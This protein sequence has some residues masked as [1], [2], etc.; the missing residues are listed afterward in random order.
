M[1]KHNM[2]YKLLAVG[3]AIVIWA[4]SSP[5]P[6]PPV[7]KD[8][9]LPLDVRRVEPGCVVTHAPKSVVVRL[10][11]ARSHVDAVAAEPDSISAFVSLQGKGPGRH[12]LPVILKLPEGYVGL[13]NTVANPRRVQV[14]VSE[15]AR[16]VLDVGVQFVGSPPV[17]YRFGIP[18]I[19]PDRAVVSG[20]AQLV[21]RVARVAAIIDISGPN[22]GSV[23]SEFGL[24][25]LDAAGKQIQGVDIAPAKVHVRL[26]LLE[27]P[28]SRAVFVSLNA[29]GQPAF[30]YRVSDIS[31]RPSTVT[32]RGRPESLVNVT[33]L[34]TEP[35][36][37]DNRTHTFSQRVRVIV[38]EGLSAVDT[39]HVR[40][41]VRIEKVPQPATENA[42]KPAT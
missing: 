9:R 30:P 18:Q 8:V 40:V 29:L 4:Y 34:K 37:L 13:V 33:T 27:A 32:V 14:I 5:G 21:N 11:G 26:D 10:Q 22:P 1:L 3:I 28:A 20:V 19:T 39:S 7:T 2:G 36:R 42:E 24:V 41:T 16:R 12:N 15:E 35:I 23:N 17:G 31:V 38:P 6:N 25:A